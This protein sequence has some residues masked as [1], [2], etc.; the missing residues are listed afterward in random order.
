MTAQRKATMLAPTGPPAWREGQRVNW[1]T[2]QGNNAFQITVAGIVRK[3][4]PT[5]VMIEV[6]R[7][8]NGGWRRQ[9]RWVAP[10]RLTPR[11]KVVPEL[12][13]ESTDT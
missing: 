10:E 9:M 12:G 4:H 2:V 3:V 13:E 1:T 11:T 5:R 7:R 6:A 8:I